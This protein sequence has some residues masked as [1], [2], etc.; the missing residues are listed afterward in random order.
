[1]NA[2]LEEALQI[3]CGTSTMWAI[4]SHPPRGV[5]TL[6]IAVLVV[7]GGPQYRVGS[8]RQFVS[9]G[10]ALARQGMTTVRFD[11]RGMGDSAGDLRSFEQVDADIRAALSAMRT[12]CPTIERFVVWG[13]CDAAAA[14]LMFATSES[15]VAGIV[16]ANPWAR[17]AATLGAVHVKHYY[18]H[19]L[20]EAAFWRKLLRG[21]VDWRQSARSLVNNLRQMRSRRGAAHGQSFQQRMADGLR[22]YEGE[23][24]L[25][26]SG[27]DLTAME[28]LEYTRSANEW[29]GL[30]E[31][32]HV[33]RV[34]LPEADHTFSRRLWAEQ[35][36]QATIQWVRRLAGAQPPTTNEAT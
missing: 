27:S 12:L 29:R 34:D 3:P 35:A 18:T 10:R 9:L 22:R 6:P 30:L 16:A 11:Y 26:I 14:A 4:A 19:R 24:L 23:L 7:V 33:T 36:E 32:R 25:I 31:A 17:S 21:Q 15:T 20:L 13:L 8:H 5:A 1:V 2:P 28:F